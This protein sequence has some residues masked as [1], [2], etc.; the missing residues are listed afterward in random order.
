ME[1]YFFFFLA[2]FFFATVCVTSLLSRQV[3]ARGCTRSPSCAA[4]LLLLGLCLFLR[5]ALSPPPSTG[6]ERPELEGAR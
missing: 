5:H 2:A 1:R 6:V 3:S 4:L